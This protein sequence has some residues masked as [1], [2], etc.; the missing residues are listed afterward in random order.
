MCVQIKDKIIENAKRTGWKRIIERHKKLFVEMNENEVVETAK[1]YEKILMD[2]CIIS[3]CNTIPS[4]SLSV[5]IRLSD[6][7]NFDFMADFEEQQQMKRAPDGNKVMKCC[8]TCQKPAEKKCSRCEV[9][10]YCC[11]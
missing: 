5:L 9:V 7:Y 6:A 10:F 2:T 4:H 3:L 11:R 8:S 1:R